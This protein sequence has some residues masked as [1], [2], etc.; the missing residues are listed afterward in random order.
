MSDT[1][2]APESPAQTVEQE[3]PWWLTPG[4]IA[5]DTETTGTNPDTDRIVPAAIVRY[6]NGQPVEDREWLLKIDIP[7]SQAS[8][9]VH[10]IT[11]ERSQSEGIEQLQALT[12][13]H[14]YLTQAK[15][16]IVA[17]NATFDIAMLNANLARHGMTPI[18]DTPIICPYV[19]DKQFNKYVRGRNQRRLLPTIQRYGLDLD[20]DSWHGATADA[21]I[22]GQLFLAQIGNYDALRSYTPHD[23]S[24]DIATWRDQQDAEFDAWLAAKRAEEAGDS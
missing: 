24:S 18:V 8:T 1:P 3:A 20:E 17:F 16:P 21:A 14:H 11:N 7:I 13:I 22:T 15:L 4:F 12:E 6:I 9:D 5:F 2:N 23:L 10:G 19:L